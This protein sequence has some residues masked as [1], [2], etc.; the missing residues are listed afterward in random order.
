MKEIEYLEVKDLLCALSGHRARNLRSRVWRP[1]LGAV[2][3]VRIIMEYHMRANFAVFSIMK[4]RLRI[5]QMHEGDRG[6]VGP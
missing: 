1:S 6:T 4:E 2:A 5:V 3:V